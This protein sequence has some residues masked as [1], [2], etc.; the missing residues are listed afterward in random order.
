MGRMQG[1][2][3]S[4]RMPHS[5][6]A[7]DHTLSEYSWNVGGKMKNNRRTL[8][9]ASALAAAAIIS[10]ASA[11]PAFAATKFIDINV[12]LD[13]IP[14]HS[15]GE[16][17]MPEF[18]VEQDG[19]SIDFGDAPES[20][21]S[22]LIP[23]TCNIKIVSDSENLDDD[24]QIRGT[25]IRATY[26]DY[27]DDSEAS[28]R[29][30]VYPFYRLIAPQPT[31]DY[32]SKK[33][34]WA[35]VPYAGKYEYVISYETKSGAEKTVHGTTK[36]CYVNIGNYTSLDAGGKVGIAV[37]ALS[38]SEEAYVK[39]EVD[40]NGVARWEGMEW[41]N[42]YRVR[43]SYKNA[44]GTTTKHE[45]TVEGTSMD[46]QGY[47]NSAQ[48]REFTVTVRA[49]P[50]TESS[51]YYNIALSEFGTAGDRNVD[52]S[53]YD[54]DNPWEL[55]ADY[56]AVVEGDFASNIST[57]AGAGVA[58]YMT[59]PSSNNDG[60]WNRVAYRWQYLV[61]GT[62]YNAGWKQISGAWYYFDADGFAHTG[63]LTDTDGKM[64]YLESR[65]GAAYGQM[66]T[67]THTINAKEYTF[68][69]DGALIG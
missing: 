65:V 35:E 42:R 49:I 17:F 67:G 44:A 41:A 3:A 25:G 8:A 13:N 36:Q 62:P 18:E 54:V 48:G 4:D 55:L 21:A 20:T 66:Y 64:Y 1:G 14:E 16:A 56:Q 32:G 69:T 45:F 29:L 60:T 61:G 31:V 34:S 52:T 57:S 46:V 28:A 59:G 43:I 58:G 47:K 23:Y 63:W 39:A 38:T 68:G 37:R 15:A 24:L 27:V 30:Q 10:A 7:G 6:Y 26:V 51:K 9:G 2:N 5:S 11:V 33:A 40:D 53:D 22:P 12:D 50:K 19:I